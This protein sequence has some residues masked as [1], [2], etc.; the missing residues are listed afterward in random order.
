MTWEWFGRR[1]DRWIP[2]VQ[3]LQP[4]PNVRFIA[5]HPN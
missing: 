5:K 1:V 3:I 2:M 4:Y